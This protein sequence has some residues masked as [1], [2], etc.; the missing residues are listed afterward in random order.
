MYLLPIYQFIYELYSS[1]EI[2]MAYKTP[3]ALASKLVKKIFN[4]KIN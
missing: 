1:G 3:Y 2:T 4:F